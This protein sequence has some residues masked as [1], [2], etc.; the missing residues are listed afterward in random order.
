MTRSDAL[1]RRLAVRAWEDPV[2]NA[3]SLALQGPYMEFCWLGVIGPTAA[4]TLR[5]LAL[6]LLAGPE[7]LEVDLPSLA[8]D[9]GLGHSSAKLRSALD[10]LVRFDLARWAAPAELEVATVLPPI[11]PRHLS[12]LS[13]WAR[14]YHFE[15]L[16]AASPHAEAG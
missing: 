15:L 16:A 7:A 3:V 12:R 14:R 8:Q 9:L 13:P 5:R 10:R 2:R 11:H 1:V 4:W 6:P